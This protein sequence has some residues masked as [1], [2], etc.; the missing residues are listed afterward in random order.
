MKIKIQTLEEFA[1]NEKVKKFQKVEDIAKFAL[2]IGSAAAL[3]AFSKYKNYDGKKTAFVTIGGGV[4]ALGLVF[5]NGGFKSAWSGTRGKSKMQNFI[6]KN[7][8][9]N[10]P[11]ETKQA[12]PFKTEIALSK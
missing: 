12:I 11:P 7:S 1:Y 9:T 5:W 3:F 4:I 10:T 8:K 6:F 2:P